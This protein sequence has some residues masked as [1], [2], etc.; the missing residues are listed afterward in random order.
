MLG[1][2]L[3]RPL[4]LLVF[5]ALALL[6]AALAVSLPSTGFTQAVTTT[7]TFDADN[8]GTAITIDENTLDTI[9]SYSATASN[10]AA[11]AYHL[12][13]PDAGDFYIHSGEDGSNGTVFNVRGFDF[14]EADDKTLDFT[15]NA[16]AD[17]VTATKD[18]TVTVAEKNDRPRFLANAIRCT[19]Q[20]QAPQGSQLSCPGTD[21]GF[22]EDQDGDSLTYSLS[23]SRMGA[24]LTIS[25]SSGVISVTEEGH[26]KLN[27]ENDELD[28]G[29][30]QGKFHFQVPIWVS[31]GKDIDGN[32][33]TETDDAASIYVTVTELTNEAP[34]LMVRNNRDGYKNML[35]FWSTTREKVQEYQVEYR[36]VGETEWQAHD[37]TA[38]DALDED[39]SRGI[40]TVIGVYADTEYEIRWKVGE[41]TWRPG[42]NRVTTHPIDNQ[43]P[44]IPAVTVLT[45]AEN[46]GPNAL[47]RPGNLIGHTGYDYATDQNEMTYRLEDVPGETPAASKF[48]VYEEVF[49]EPLGLHGQET[50]ILAVESLD[51]ESASSYK[52]L[53]TLSD[54]R[55]A[56]GAKDL[57]VDV[58]QV[59]TI[60]VTNVFEHPDAPALRAAAMGPNS[61]RL[62]W[63][64]PATYEE[65]A[66]VTAYWIEYQ[67]PGGPRLGRTKITGNSTLIERLEPGT[68]Y[69][70]SGLTVV[71]PKHPG[72]WSS[73]GEAVS[74]TTL[75]AGSSPV[76]TPTPGPTQTP[77]PTPTPAPEPTPTPTPAPTATPTPT[78]PPTLAP[79]PTPEPTPAPTPTPTP[80]PAPTLA[81]TPTPEPTPTPPGPVTEKPGRPT[82]LSSTAG[83]GSLTLTWDPP[84]SGGAVESYVVRHRLQGGGNPWTTLPSTQATRLEITDL[85]PGKYVI[86]VRAVNALGES[87]AA[88]VRDTVR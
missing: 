17:G 86:R 11:V 8:S 35:V 16:T 41:E 60:R 15:V 33:D 19:I 87:N 70:F 5:A 6:I 26:L 28:W 34:T 40:Y 67:E 44:K 23:D 84:A 13:G 43:P 80:T 25:S 62:E 63:D 74:A 73:W 52:V 68:T 54:G 55:S 21:T 85:P 32:P 7:V 42:L 57:S 81:P 1:T 79:T 69:E 2:L 47:L 51:Y 75:S 4:A 76:P 30:A 59:V 46:A 18:V 31:D 71:D 38:E 72:T 53:L 36:A 83:S 56:T 64:T 49:N 78:P 20:E 48:R 22:A 37:L 12:T 66:A 82:N 14:E 88:T 10:G 61:V 77:E 58:S 65:G 9:G 27:H 24:Y 50:Q 39:F 3:N 45:I 29:N